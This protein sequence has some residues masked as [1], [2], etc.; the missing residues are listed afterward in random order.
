MAHKT[1]R[2][3]ADALVHAQGLAESRE[4]ARRLIMAGKV[5]LED[6][7]L[8]VTSIRAKE[9]WRCVTAKKGGCQ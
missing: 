2:Q 7:G 5:A 8:T 6:A 9:E 4:Q 1:A 3:R